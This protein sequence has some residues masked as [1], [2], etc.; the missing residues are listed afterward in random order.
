MFN[1]KLR[2]PQSQTQAYLLVL[3]CVVTLLGCQGG[4]YV[5]SPSLDQLIITAD[6]TFDTAEAL[7]EGFTPAQIEKRDTKRQALYNEAITQ[8]LT[9]L[10][11]DTKGRYTQRAHHEIAKLYTRRYQFDKAIEHYQ[12][13]LKL[14]NIGYYPTQAKNSMENIRNNQEVVKDQLAKYNNAKTL[15]NQQPS[16]QTLNSAVE[17]LDSMAQA[18]REIKNYPEAIRTYQKIV[19]EYPQHEKAPHAQFEIGNIYFYNLYD[20]SETGGWGAFVA[21]H[22]KY[23]NTAEGKAVVTLLKKAGKLFREIRE[24]QGKI[25]RNLDHR[26]P[27]NGYTEI[28]FAG[29]SPDGSERWSPDRIIH[30]FQ[31]I[32]KNWVEMRNYP[33]AIQTYKNLFAE[34]VYKKNIEYKKFAAADALYN[35]A[36]LYQQNKQFER[37]IHAY[38]NLFKK[39][40]KTSN[41]INP[42]IYQQAVCYHAMQKYSDA[43][44]GF[45]TYI[46][47]AKND[48]NASY[49]QEAKQIIH[50]FEQDQ[51]KDGYRYYKEQEN[52]TSDQDPNSHP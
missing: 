33:R 45:K 2:V 15:Y 3:L 26:Y 17:S 30:S 52:G 22:E 18:Y 34:M 46:R 13:I 48:K 6:N 39:V 12:A 21:V 50:Q 37:A 38:N 32:A 41:R 5:F 31:I 9:I 44:K 8:Y 40:S 42:S 28:R 20:Y 16:E 29:H 49:L 11:K 35:I 27:K 51:D 10:E 24:L 23:P 36:N 4:V 25:Q 1:F 7:H 47:L 19:E 43:Y 14:T